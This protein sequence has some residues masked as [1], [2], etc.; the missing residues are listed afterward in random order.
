M[1]T[2]DK[3]SLDSLRIDRTQQRRGSRW[4]WVLLLLLP[5]IGA[6]VFLKLRSKPV[7]VKA[8][9]VV[10]RTTSGDN[11]A[12]T[13]TVLNASGYVTARRKATV[14]SKTTGKIVEVMIEE[15]VRVNEGDVLAT[16]D[17][18]NV[19]TSFRLADA[20]LDSATSA[21]AETRVRLE[22][23]QREFRRVQKL[24]AEKV[25]SAAD[26]DNAEAEAKS[27]QARL[28]RQQADIAVAERQ[29]EFYRQQLNDLIIRAPFRGVVVSKDAQPGEM[30]SP[31]SAGGGFTRTGVCTLVD[32]SSLEIE[33]DV[34]EAYINRVKTD[35]PVTATLDAYP[36]WSIP[37][38]VIAIIPTADR[39]KATVKV[40]IAFEK[41]DDRI[42]PE[43][44]VKVA[45]QE[46]ANGETSPLNASRK[47]I[48]P[49]T[50]VHS[51]NGRDFV[52]LLAEGV[53]ARRNVVVGAREAD[54]A[55]MDSG[56]SAG[57]EVIISDPSALKEGQRATTSK[58]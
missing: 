1:G 51:E 2:T 10:E 8:F 33:I 43:M 21:L 38:H 3:A 44:G 4:P 13:A 57:E 19:D 17:S 41:L 7:L 48:I 15:G 52:W 24:V 23:A 34:N 50:A 29:I 31:V 53:V 5:V 42:L 49:T 11:Q 56:L 47:L 58:P 14:S 22:Q 36:H 45:F 54:T 39:Q 20:Q 46:G 32:M 9:T 28:I 40:R 12:A 55:L 37:G 26:Y 30:I 35:Q 16:L 6:A 18:S 27:L 25:A